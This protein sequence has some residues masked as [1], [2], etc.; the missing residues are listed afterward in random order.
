[1]SENVCPYCGSKKISVNTN[2]SR[3]VEYECGTTKHYGVITDKLFINRTKMCLYAEKLLNEI[4]TLKGDLEKF[5]D[6]S[7]YDRLD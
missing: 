4:K 7:E 3:N 5:L 2:I 1:M 6:P